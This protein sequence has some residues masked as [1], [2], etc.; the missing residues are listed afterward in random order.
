MRRLRTRSASPGMVLGR[1]VLDVSGN[2]VC[3]IGE[4]ISQ[5]V[6]RTLSVY[7]VD[8]VFIEDARTADASVGPLVAPELEAEA[9]Q[10]L[11]QVMDESKR[12]EVAPDS[13]LKQAVRPLEEMVRKFGP[14]PIGEANTSPVS[15]ESDLPFRLPARAAGMAAYVALRWGLRETG[16]VTAAMSTLLMDVGYARLPPA[17]WAG[18]A[19]LAGDSQVTSDFQ[20][21][22]AHSYLLLKDSAALPSDVLRAVLEHEERLNGSGYPRKLKGDSI[23]KYARIAAVTGT[24][25][26]LISC[27]RSKNAM[28]R[29]E[30]VEYILAYGGELF[31]PEVA[32]LFA[33]SVPAYPAGT[34]VRLNTGE[35]GVVI[36]SKAGH[37]G[38][39]IVRLMVDDLGYSMRQPR[40]VDLTA[41]AERDRMVADTPEF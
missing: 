25:F 37:I 11:R 5:D 32:T 27:V 40:D 4:A 21:H 14:V 24:Y 18:A 31:D 33:R 15:S 36:D 20:K 1:A 16:A 10:A 13:L 19:G 34:M 22:P 9:A 29:H 6:L 7:G 17:M 26:A 39:P 35:T 12:L 28:R 3:A 2:T 23:N 8:E 38:R 41:P 30:A